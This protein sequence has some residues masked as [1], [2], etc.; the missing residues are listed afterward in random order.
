MRYMQLQPQPQ[1]LADAP[2]LQYSEEQQQQAWASYYA[3]QQ[4]QYGQYPQPQPQPAQPYQRPIYPAMAPQVRSVS[5]SRT[6]LKSPARPA[7]AVFPSL[8]GAIVRTA[9]W[10]RSFHCRALKPVQARPTD[11]MLLRCG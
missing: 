4:Q 1:Q 3:Q 11:I 7:P 2:H 10:S 6:A 5:H 8:C 9:G